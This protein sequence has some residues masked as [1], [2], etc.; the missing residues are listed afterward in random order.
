M[1]CLPS[2]TR[3]SISSGQ[4]WWQP[5][6]ELMVRIASDYL[7]CTSCTVLLLR[8]RMVSA[9][10]AHHHLY[11]TLC[12]GCDKLREDALLDCVDWSV[13]WGHHL[14][15]KSKHFC[16]CERW[17]ATSKHLKKQQQRWS[18]QHPLQRIQLQSRKHFNKPQ[19]R[20]PG[21]K[22]LLLAFK[23]TS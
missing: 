18:R 4:I 9:V 6:R 23:R 22:A 15:I 13:G 11:P 19:A 5:F 20:K 16:S 3:I 14:R 17:R 10:L 2:S 8:S 7:L 12:Y 1:K 21:I